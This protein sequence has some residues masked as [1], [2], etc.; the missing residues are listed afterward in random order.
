MGF[1]QSLLST[2][3]SVLAAIGR[4]DILRTLGIVNSITVMGGF[5]FGLQFGL[6]GLVIAYFCT[7]TLITI[8]SIH[9][10]LREVDSGLVELARRIWKQSLCAITMAGLLAVL[11]S[12]MQAWVPAIV[13]LAALVPLGVAFYALSLYFFSRMLLVELRKAL[14]H[15]ASLGPDILP[16]C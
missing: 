8:T 2:T 13:V 9:V 7:T 14:W 5:V 15:K 4:T 12:F 11:N 3:G 10:T 6:M 16:V 1:L